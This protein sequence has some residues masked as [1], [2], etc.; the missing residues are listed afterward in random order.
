M[1]PMVFVKFLIISDTHDLKPG[2]AE[3][4]GGHFEPLRRRVP[5]ADVILHC[6]DLTQNG[7]I[8]YYKA[9]LKMLGAMDAELKI[10]TAGNHDLDLDREYFESN[11]GGRY[12]DRTGIR[13][14]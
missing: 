10:V 6:G 7:G 4:V 1:P 5:R 3:E 8:S 14:R 12:D 13:K 2:D 9:A 11:L